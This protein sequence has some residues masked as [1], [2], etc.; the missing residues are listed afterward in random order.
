MTK[1]ENHEEEE[2]KDKEPYKYCFPD[3]LARFMKLFDD[4][5]Q[6]EASMLS[7]SLLMVGLILFTIYLVVYS[8]WNWWMKGMTIFN[9]L[10]GLILM[11][12]NLITTFQ[13]YQ[14]LRETQDIVGN[15]GT[16]EPFPGQTNENKEIKEDLNLKKL[17][18]GK[19]I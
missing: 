16:E 15:F 5:T 11:F 3:P 8:N 2:L 12:S 13:Q 10:C 19:K 7:M 1:E 18:G 14:Q 6:M 9:S 4:R 17:K